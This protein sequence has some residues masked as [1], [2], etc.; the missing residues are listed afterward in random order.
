MKQT[1][2]Y[3]GTETDKHTKALEDVRFYLGDRFAFVMDAVSKALLVD[4]ED[5]VESILADEKLM[6]HF[7]FMLS[8]AGIEGY[9]V[10]AIVREIATKKLAKIS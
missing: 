5:T 8:F 7:H 3:N 6:D 10:I 1:K 9:P 4:A 2:H